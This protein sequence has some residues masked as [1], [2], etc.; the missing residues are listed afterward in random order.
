[1]GRDNPNTQLKIKRTF[2]LSQKAEKGL[3]YLIWIFLVSRIMEGVKNA[4]YLMKIK[5]FMLEMEIEP[6]MF[7]FQVYLLNIIIIVLCAGF[8]LLYYRRARK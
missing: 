3:L 6:L 1:M 2:N 8:L 7:F 4:Y 5:P